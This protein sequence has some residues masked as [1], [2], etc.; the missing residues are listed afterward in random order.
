MAYKYAK[1]KVFRGD[2]YYEDDTQGN[3]YLDWSEDALA[4]IVGG[5]SAF[6]VSG[7]NRQISASY[8]LS[9][10]SFYGDGSN[11]SN[12]G[13]GGA[14]TD[15][16][17]VTLATDGD[18]SAERVL[19]AGS[20]IS[21]ADAGAG[22]AITISTA[23]A[24]TNIQAPFV[25]GSAN[26]Y[27]QQISG[28]ENQ[29]VV[30]NNFASGVRLTMESQFTTDGHTTGSTDW[31]SPVSLTMAITASSDTTGSYDITATNT[32]GLLYTLTDGVVITSGEEISLD[33]IGDFD[34]VV[35]QSMVGTGI[36]STGADWA[37]SN[38]SISTAQITTGV[39]AYV[40]IKVPYAADANK[41][42]F[43]GLGYL[44]EVDTSTSTVYAWPR[45]N[46]YGNAVTNVSVYATGTLLQSFTEE[47]FTLNSTW[48]VYVLNNVVSARVKYSGEDDFETM[49]T[50]AE[51]VDIA[52]NSNLVAGF[53]FGSRYSSYGNYFDT[54][55]LYGVLTNEP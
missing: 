1:G 42:A 28:S 12:V 29:N 16:Q 52:S 55:K 47:E 24:A 15:A 36:R 13:G 32:D 21:L 5:E 3:T 23:V 2:I 31:N 7:S 17:Y 6:I 30:G 37:W 39:E 22:G 10:S 14:P 33:A 41:I 9:A 18:L 45:W 44:D 27:I 49:Y 46:I 43:F 19:T 34:E 4:I 26:T 51:E 8:N 53:T 25:S 38:G 40:E 50:W 54:I 35:N 11:L 48:R 20:G